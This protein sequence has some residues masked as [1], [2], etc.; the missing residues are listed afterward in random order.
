M[1]WAADQFNSESVLFRES[2]RFDMGLWLRNLL[3]DR[4]DT[5]SVAEAVFCGVLV[6]TIKFF[7][8]FALQPS[9]GFWGFVQMLMVVQ[10]VVIAT[11]ALI[12]TIM[13]TRNPRRTL[14]LHRP[15]WAAVPAALLLA[16]ALHPAVTLLQRIVMQVYPL[17]EDVARQLNSLLPKDAPLGWSLLIIALVPAMCEE[18]AFRG[19]ILSG[20]RH[21]GHKWR[22]IALSSIF[23]GVMHSIFQQSII[24]CIVGLAL[25]FIAVQ[26][27]SLLPA[28]TFHAV[29]NSLGL[30]THEYLPAWLDKNPLQRW[31][32]TVGAEQ[33]ISFS[34][35]FIAL[36]AA[37]SALLLVWFQ[38][39][40]YVRT[41]EEKLQE[42]IDQQAAQ[43]AG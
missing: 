2:E 22:A 7:M 27:G 43:P 28:I 29:H 17:S 3:R 13:L 12:M 14:L 42:A 37:A 40:S 4:E 32:A 23:F 6:L 19:F 1:R 11:P 31:I 30:L 35:P 34:W 39:L 41:D 16:V 5:P 33:E 15:P 18:L 9:P 21:M 20:L 26:T 25:G 36:T 10:L 38:R 24:A 8:G